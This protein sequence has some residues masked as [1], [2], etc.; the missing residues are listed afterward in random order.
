M[1]AGHRGAK[2]PGPEWS[3]QPI[4]RLR[5]VATN[6][7]WTLYYHRH[8]DRWERYPLLEATRDV[9]PLL[10]ELTN[11]PMAVFRG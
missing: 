10:R 7:E 3:R 11:D 1:S 6:K 9:A 4:A 8:T 2:Q 5:Y